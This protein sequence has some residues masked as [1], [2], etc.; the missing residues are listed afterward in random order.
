MPSFFYFKQG[1]YNLHFAL[2]DWCLY[3]KTGQETYCQ[4]FYQSL[5]GE[6]LGGCE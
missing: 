6:W 2:I 5:N 4:D 1:F 3:L